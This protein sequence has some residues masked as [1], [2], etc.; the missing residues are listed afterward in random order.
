MIDI[1]LAGSPVPRRPSQERLTNMQLSVLQFF[2]AFMYALFRREYVLAAVLGLYIGNGVYVHR[3]TRGVDLE[4]GDLRDQFLIGAWSVCN[5]YV[6]LTVTRP[7]L[8]IFAIMTAVL[9]PCLAVLRLQWVLGSWKRDIVHIV[10][11]VSACLGT[12]V[13]LHGSSR[14]SYYKA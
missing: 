12:I 8:Q 1:R 11:H 13:I 7:G 3:R 4:T 6:L 14:V 5:L 2:V 9:V 10:M